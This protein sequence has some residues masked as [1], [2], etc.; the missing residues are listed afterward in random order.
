MAGFEFHN[1]DSLKVLAAQHE[2][3]NSQMRD[4]LNTM[5]PFTDEEKEL[6]L[7]LV[8]HFVAGSLKYRGVNLDED[9]IHIGDQVFADTLLTGVLMGLHGWTT[10]A[11]IDSHIEQ[12]V[13][14]LLKDQNTNNN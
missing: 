3:Y 8:V 4:A 9:S 7:D 12:I 10:F 6:A 13:G 14:H 11:D 2:E 5:R 1:L